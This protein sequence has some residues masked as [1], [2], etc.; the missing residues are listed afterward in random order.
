MKKFIIIYVL[1]ILNMHLCFAQEENKGNNKDFG[2]ALGLTEYQ[3]SDKVLN[4][5]RHRGIFPSLGFSYEWLGEVTRQRIELYLIFNMLKSRYDPDHN[6]FIINPSLNYRYVRKVKD[7][8]PNLDLLIGGKTGLYSHQAYFGNWDDSH[9]YW[10]TYYYI[11]FDGM[12][13]Y[14]KSEESSFDLEINIPIISLV[15]RPPERF[16]Y[17]IM[18]NK[19]SWIVNEIHSNLKFTSIHQNLVL[20]LN[21]GYLFS[22]SRKFK[23]KIFCRIYY[24]NNSMSYS[25]EI[26]ILTY[27]LGAIFLF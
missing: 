20:D 18:D 17:K 13:T 27:I 21:L 9:I 25:K 24:I 5:I 26:S 1:L 11:G 6:T 23:Q 15:S 4:N 22:Y 8:T 7:I 19:F 2:I 14:Q 10:L 16:L 12:V 3:V